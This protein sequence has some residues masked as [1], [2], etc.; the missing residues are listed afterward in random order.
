MGF[1]QCAAVMKHTRSTAAA[2][3]PDSRP[4]RRETAP[5]DHE[6]GRARPPNRTPWVSAGAFLAVIAT[7]ATGVLEGV[8]YPLVIAGAIICGCIGLRQ[9]HPKLMWPWWALVLTGVLWG[10]AGV[11]REGHRRNWGPHR[12]PVAA[13]RSLRPSRLRACSALPSTAFCRRALHP[14]G[15]RAGL[16]GIMLGAGALLLVNELLIVPTLH[17]EGAWLMARIAIAIYPAISMCLLVL[18]ARLA[19]SSWQR[20]PA[21]Y[22]AARRHGVAVAR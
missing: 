18:A 5:D 3:V 11:V 14:R 2:G 16:D 17:I 6:D 10:L 1:A 22:P 8:T 21:F 19:F 7:D 13:P 12:E 20:S 4:Y 9:H 15:P